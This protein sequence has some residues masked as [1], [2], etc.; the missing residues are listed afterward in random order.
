MALFNIEKFVDKINS[1]KKLQNTIF[2][3]KQLY[4]LPSR[5]G[6]YLSFA[7]I[8]GIGLSN[9]LENNFLLLILL[10]QMVRVIKDFK[11]LKI[12]KEFLKETKEK[13]LVEW[14]L[15]VHQG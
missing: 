6:I 3:I 5:F 11:Q 4:A 8:G 10:F 12:T 14:A 9:R 15:I 2:S 1:K 13:I 7:I